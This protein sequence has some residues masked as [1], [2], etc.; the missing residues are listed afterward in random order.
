MLVL[1]THFTCA[2]RTLTVVMLQLTLNMPA[3]MGNPPRL[4]T[5]IKL[6][7]LHTGLVG[8]L[9]SGKYFAS[10][11]VAAGLSD[12]DGRDTLHVASVVHLGLENTLVG[13]ARCSY[14][15][16]NRHRKTKGGCC[17]DCFLLL[18]FF[19]GWN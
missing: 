11:A 2:N 7:V 1:R 12:R 10:R 19:I 14:G 4:H 16:Q 18:L 17:C 5:A 6:R 3:K 15:N 9:S 13:H 8:R